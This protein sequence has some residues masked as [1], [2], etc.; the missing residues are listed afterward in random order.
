MKAQQV[1]VKRIMGVTMGREWFI[2]QARRRRLDPGLRV[3]IN[4]SFKRFRY[5]CVPAFA[6]QPSGT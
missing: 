3:R 6:F 4:R 2:D 5:K 1:P